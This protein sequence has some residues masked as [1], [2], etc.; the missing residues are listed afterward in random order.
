MYK[1]C[2]FYWVIYGHFIRSVYVKFL[3]IKVTYKY[4]I[5]YIRTF[6]KKKYISDIGQST[7]DYS[8]FVILY[9]V[10]NF[11]TRSDT[12]GDITIFAIK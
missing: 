10:K 9:Q 5:L 6:F 1:Y 11:E 7:T 2:L 8:C 12:Q 4:C 3:C